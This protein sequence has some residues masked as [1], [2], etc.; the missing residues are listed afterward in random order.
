VLHYH[1]LL[2]CSTLCLQQT[3]DIQT[4]TVK[5]ACVL[6]PLQDSKQEQACPAGALH[7]TMP[8]VHWP[9]P[10]ML[11]SRA[12]SSSTMQA[13]SRNRRKA[14]RHCLPAALLLYMY[15]V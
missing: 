12:D 9:K 3:R 8:R 4:V 14:C 1:V 11:L 5:L 13:L 2:Q 7:N 15:K 10:W 6:G